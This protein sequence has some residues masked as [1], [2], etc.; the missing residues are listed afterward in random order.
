MHVSG[1]KMRIVSRKQNDS[2][3][4]NSSVVSPLG[5]ECFL[6]FPL[7][8]ACTDDFQPNFVIVAMCSRLES[9]LSGSWIFN[10]K[11]LLCVC[12]RS[13]GSGCST[14]A[15]G[16]SRAWRAT[17]WRWAAPGLTCLPPPTAESSACTGPTACKHASR[18]TVTYSRTPYVFLPFTCNSASFGFRG[19]E[20]CLQGMANAT[21]SGMTSHTTCT[22][23]GKVFDHLLLLV[24][25]VI[26]V[27]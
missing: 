6:P 22:C 23:S 20:K 15:R 4:L 21:I 24:V 14:W 10:D 9:V 18:T 13:T 5:L 3:L 7:S 25:I 17:W 16:T 8:W 19:K 11:Q 26:V 1:N 27:K 12:D 2:N